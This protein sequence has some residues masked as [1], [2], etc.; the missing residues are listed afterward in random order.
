MAKGS[1][2]A[3]VVSFN[4]LVSMAF[5]VSYRTALTLGAC[6]GLVQP[7]QRTLDPT[8]CCMFVILN[9]VCDFLRP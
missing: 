5:Y 7:Q 3:P 4:D 1:I 9:K 8:E 2:D 6:A